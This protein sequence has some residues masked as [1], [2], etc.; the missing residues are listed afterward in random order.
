MNKIEK[1]FEKWDE[2]NPLVGTNTWDGRVYS[3]TEIEE[4]F[5][6]GF[7]QGEEHGA[8]QGRMKVLK[9][10]QLIVDVNKTVGNITIEASKN[11][12]LSAIKEYIDSELKT[13]RK[14]K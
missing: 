1:A 4:I 11:V 7:K 10:M 8:K 12:I 6:A 2:D 13:L 14:S 5:T 9:E 3:D